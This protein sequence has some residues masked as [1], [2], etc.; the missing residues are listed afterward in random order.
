M[1]LKPK[2]GI[3]ICRCGTNIADKLKFDE[4]KN[5]ISKLPDVA[6]VFEDNFFCAPA[7]K[8]K[9]IETIKKEKLNRCCFAACSHRV[10]EKTFMS[11][12]EEAGLNPYLIQ[13][14]NLREH[15]TWV[16]DDIEAAT[17]KAFVQISAAIERLHYHEEIIKKFLE[18]KTDIAIIGGGMTGIKAAKLLAQDKSRTIYLIE[19]EPTLG[20]WMPKWEKSYP[21]MDCNPCFLAPEL[22][23]IKNITNLKV[24]T[25]AQIDEIK[26]FYG[27]FTINLTQKPRFITDSCIGC[28]ECFSQCPV[29]VKNEFNAGMDERKAV[30]IVFP[31]SYPNTA[32]IDEKSCLRFK[33]ENCSKC[34]EGCPF[35]AVDYNQKPEQMELSVGGIIIASGFDMIDI[36]EFQQYN[37]TGKTNIFTN[38]EF[39]RMMSSSGPTQGHIKTR[40]NKDPESVAVVYCGGRQK[41]GYCS[42]VCCGAS[43]K[44]ARFLLGHNPGVKICQIYS[45][46]CLDTE[47]LQKMKSD[48]EKDGVKFIKC[49]DYAK[50]KLEESA[51]SVT[52]KFTQ[53]NS[54]KSEKV[55]M[56]VVSMGIKN[57]KN[58]EELAKEMDLTLSAEGWFQK[59]HAKMEPSSSIIEG[60]YIA[61]CCSTPGDVQRSVISAKAAAGEAMSKLLA[62]KKIELEPAVATINPNLCAGCRLCVSVCPFKAISFD[63][64]LKIS[65]V[66]E[67]ICRGCGTCVGACPAGAATAK[68]FTYSQIYAEIGGVLV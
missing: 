40:D 37:W 12:A 46:L 35:G 13:L 28:M 14:V 27:N 33:G 2:I 26:G 43:M 58:S 21:T 44:Y 24:I 59:S 5:Q 1:S 63:K 9:I 20:G 31:G 8:Q 49:D 51:G 34:Q 29:T 60:I 18:V 65:V 55:N 30:Y 42:S 38:V 57:S 22:S 7:G 32:V 56:A 54:E 16:C 62:G 66:N 10:H 36:K 45:E 50:I 25:S 68:H 39:E 52:I 3:F 11:I 17:Q 41:S 61:G 23:E 6:G 48:L 67:A 64:N 53:N 47:G 19:K 4:L 15:I